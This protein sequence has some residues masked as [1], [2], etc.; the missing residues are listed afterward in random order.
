MRALLIL[1]PT[2]SGKSALAMALAA[3][4]PVEIISV[5][6]AQVY[7]GL[8]VGTAKPTAA[9][10]A[11]VPHHLIDIRDPADP[12]SAARFV[13]D[14]APLIGQ[15]AARG[16]LPLL[17]GG[18]MLYARALITPFDPL[19]PA[20]P[21]I[22]R[23]LEQEAQT[24]GWALLH[25]RLAA[26]DPLSAGRIDPG[27]PQRIQRALEVIEITGVTLSSLQRRRRSGEPPADGEAGDHDRSLPI[28][29]LEPSDRV[30]LHQRIARRFEQM[31]A[32]GLVDEVRGLMARPDLH[33]ELPALR[34]VGYRQ[35]W[36]YLAKGGT[37]RSGDGPLRETGIAATRQLAKRQLT[38]LR[39]LPVHRRLD[40]LDD[41]VPGQASA[42]I[43]QL[44][45]QSPAAAGTNPGATIT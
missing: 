25:R 12:Y 21:A 4:L 23:R 34:S 15:I 40:C 37:A 29:S 36:Q 28:L 42:I 5:D 3:R 38:W 10:R 20:E 7:R 45:R 8:D 44:W 9:E 24:H 31:L 39:S 2:A 22:R 11:Q 27:D 32:D 30:V 6:S 26:L 41:R 14:A 35:V 19:P 43:D 17:V 16:R 33:P 13:A 1:G 18:T